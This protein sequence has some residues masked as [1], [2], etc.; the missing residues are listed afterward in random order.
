MTFQAT[1]WLSA[2]FRYNR[3]QNWNMGG[4]TTYYDRGFD[5][6]FRVHKE[7]QYWPEI[8]LGFQDFVGTGI[9]AAEYLVATKTFRAPGF[10]GARV[11][12]K[13]KLTGGLGWGRLGT[14][15]SI[16]SPFGKD[17]PAYD[18][19]STGGEPAFDQWFRGSRSQMEFQTKSEKYPLPLHETRTGRPRP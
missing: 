9:Y 8:T 15:G 14:S 18:P 19:S 3:I 10:G 12:G 6:R 17:R 1:P 11:P 2:S 16:G 13:L 5:M 4:F 7:T